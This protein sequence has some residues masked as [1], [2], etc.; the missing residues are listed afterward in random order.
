MNL[1]RGFIV[2]RAYDMGNRKQGD[3]M[4]SLFN[5]AFH[6][7]GQVDVVEYDKFGFPMPIAVHRLVFGNGAGEG[8]GK[9]GRQRNAFGRRRSVPGNI[10]PDR[11][12]LNFKQ[13]VDDVLAATLRH[14]IKDEIAEFRISLMRACR[15]RLPDE[16]Y[17][18][19]QCR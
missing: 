12:E 17:Q 16:L 14:D 5:L 2:C 3:R 11:R 10:I 1:T 9:I 13:Q 4:R 18:L 19:R 15:R 8:F 7:D 6:H